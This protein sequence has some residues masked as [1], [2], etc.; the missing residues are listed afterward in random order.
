MHCAMFAVD[1]HQ[2]GAGS[3][4][5]RLHH[6]GTGNQALLVSQRQTTTEL[7]C[8]HRHRQAREADDTIHD[9]VGRLDQIGKIINHLREWQ[10]GDNLCTTRRIG[11][12]NYLRPKLLC[13]T[14]ERFHRTADTKR[15]DLIAIAFCAYNI[16]RLLTDRSGRTGDSDSNSYLVTQGCR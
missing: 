4:A 12:R 2:L 1:G 13:L 10:R 11:D 16:K 8:A 9:D 6:R 15:N 5:Q 7:Q 14:N 3:C